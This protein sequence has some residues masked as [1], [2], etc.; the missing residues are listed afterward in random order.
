MLMRSALFWDITQCLV[1]I[2]YRRFGTLKIGPIGFPETSVK[3]Y[4][5]ALRNIPEER[6]SKKKG[7]LPSTNFKLLNKIR[8]DIIDFS[9]VY[10][11][12]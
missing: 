1:L 2:L 9:K 4:H 11:I 3:D 10:N 5:S 6:K 8:G 12:C 7:F